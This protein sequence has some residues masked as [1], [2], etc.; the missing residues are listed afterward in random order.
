MKPR[1]LIVDDERNI[2]A[3]LTMILR[4]EGCDT[5]E[6][7]SGEEALALLEES[8]S[9]LVLLDIGLPG[10]D[11]LETLKAMK[12]AASSPAVIMISGQASIANAVEATR[13]G[14]FDFLE[15]PLSKDRVL[16]AVRNALEISSLGAEIA[17]LRTKDRER[18]VMIGDTGE[19]A[20]LRR[21]IEKVARTNATVLITG[22]SG[23]GKEL[24]AR[25]IHDGS[26]RAAKA[27]VKINCAAI[28]DELIESELFG[29]VRGAFTGA[30]RTRDGKFLLADGGT[31]FLDEV[32][33]MNARA[34]AKVLRA[35]QEG[36]I[37]RVG[38]S[39]TLRVDVRVLA[40]TNKDLPA[41][42]AAGTFREDLY[43]RLNV[44]PIH[45][46][47]LRE[48]P[49]DIPKLARHF[50]TLYAAEN[51]LPPKAFTAGALR[52]LEQH[53]WPGNVR[54][55]RNVIDRL[56]ILSE[57]TEITER[58]VREHARPVEP[59][60]PREVGAPSGLDAVRALGGLVEARRA[61]ERECIE[62][63]LDATAGNVSQAARLLNIERS[64]LHKKMQFY[65]LEARPA[66]PGRGPE[67]SEEET[68]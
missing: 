56:A 17:T 14:A 63:C 8:P 36:E 34:Q 43:F 41:E 13:R 60:G 19:M 1:V 48:R 28:P 57:Q 33:D 42:V 23:T 59:P 64:N 49:G 47:P 40:A 21:T 31:L 62:S 4:A 39:K 15:K 54:E 65:G 22:E 2:R 38:D 61:F 24:V 11:G 45:V 10:Q 30:D 20:T 55:L 26:A 67:S 3:T 44:V 6:A 12:A 35:L 9:E 50:L 46:K 25:A 51:E 29:A 5:R 68:P 27:F 7:G 32:G 58:D 52:A 37:E 53:A 66:R 16:L 18:R